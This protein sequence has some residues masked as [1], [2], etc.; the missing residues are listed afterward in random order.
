MSYLND[1]TGDSAPFEDKP[2]DS[3]ARLGTSGHCTAPRGGLDEVEFKSAMVDDRPAIL[4]AEDQIFIALEA[5]RIISEAFDCIVEICLRDH[6]S[7]TLAEKTFQVVLLEYSGL[8]Q[9]D[10]HYVSL[11]AQSGAEVAFLSAGDDFVDLRNAFPG[12]PLIRKPFSE[13]EVREVVA[14]VLARKQPA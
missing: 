13:T 11:A 2:S 12:V 6:L 3:V 1:D 8:S 7:K 9:E 10:R 4:I 5:E 14:S